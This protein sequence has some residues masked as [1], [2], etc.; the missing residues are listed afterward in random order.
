MQTTNT[1]YQD[2]AY[3]KEFCKHYLRFSLKFP[4]FLTEHPELLEQ[5]SLK[6][7]AIRD[8]F[9]ECSPTSLFDGQSLEERTLIPLGVRL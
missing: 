3:N 9:I 7:R 2:I 5:K 1:K 8:A 4:V 6:W